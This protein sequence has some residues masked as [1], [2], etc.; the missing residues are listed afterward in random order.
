MNGGSPDSMDYDDALGVL[1]AVHRAETAI[2]V[3]D[4][5]A[6]HLHAGNY[7]VDLT[8]GDH[9][10]L[11][12]TRINAATRSI[13]VRRVDDEEVKTA[14]RALPPTASPAHLRRAAH[15][16]AATI[17]INHE[18][19]SYA[20]AAAFSVDITAADYAA[21]KAGAGLDWNT[22]A[23]FTCIPHVDGKVVGGALPATVKA[24]LPRE[25]APGNRLTLEVAMHRHAPLSASTNLHG[26]KGTDAVDEAGVLRIA[27]ARLVKRQAEGGSRASSVTASPS[28]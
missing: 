4:G 9:L 24:S 26:T 28:I 1:L 12:L 17:G 19:Q 23:G 10:L 22:V 21:L 18:T 16:A 27:A 11:W 15:D 3:A 6:L 7:E 20:L 14:L 5:S 25:G 13:H 8:K 2:L